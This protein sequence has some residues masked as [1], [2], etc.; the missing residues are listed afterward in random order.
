MAA[1]QVLERQQGPGVHRKRTTNAGTGDIVV[2]TDNLSSH[3]SHATCDWL[4]AHPRT[5]HVLTSRPAPAGST[6]KRP[7]G[8]SS[9]AIALVL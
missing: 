4:A 5:R 2:I 6:C 7:G 9:G 1:P 8:G 3:N